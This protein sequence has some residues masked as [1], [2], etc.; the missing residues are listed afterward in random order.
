MQRYTHSGII[1]VSGAI[2][3]IV[4][5]LSAAVVA[6]MVYA[7][8]AY[9]ISWGPFRLIM[10]CI[11]GLTL[12]VA[13][14]VAANYGKIRSPLFN[15]VVAIVCAAFGLWIYWG[16]Y[17]VARNGVAVIPAAWGPARLQEHG[18]QL[19]EDGTFTMK[20]RDRTDGWPLVGVWVAEGISVLLIVVTLARTDAARPFCETCLEWTGSTS[21]LM[22]VAADGKEPPWQEVL[23]GDL[24]AIA[25]F[26]PANASTT[27]HVRLDLARCPKC[28]HSNFVSLTA[29]EIT[30]D[31]KGK[32]K[33]TEV[34]L[35]QNGMI[36]DPEAEFLRE[37]SQQLH[38]KGGEDEQD[39]EGEETEGDTDL[40][41]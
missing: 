11:Y 36:S 7:F 6:G 15:T 41:S 18:E 14:A 9:W 40:A 16:A 27:P 4:T 26:Q 35:L 32:T 23:G 12:G 34:T 17:D 20:G 2:T 38:G 13:I 33:T 10:M 3:T 21:G 19:F 5:G 31:S 8:F 22:R 28:Q 39:N 37:F 25:S 29:V 1:P 30:T 24:T